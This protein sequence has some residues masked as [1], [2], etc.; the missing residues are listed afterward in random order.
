LRLILQVEVPLWLAQRLKNSLYIGQ[1]KHYNERFR[2]DLQAGPLAKNLRERSPHYFSV[3]EALATLTADNDLQQSL[4]VAYTGDRFNRIM[5]LAFN[6]QD[7]DVTEDQR[8]FTDAE[9]DLFTAGAQAAKAFS[10]WKS[11]NQSSL[12]ASSAVSSS[13]NDPRR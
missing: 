8:K 6:S 9:L 4:K 5:D 2:E 3:G 11:R 7:E 10:Q 12:R 1:H 13:S